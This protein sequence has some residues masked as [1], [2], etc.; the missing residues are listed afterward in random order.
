MDLVNGYRKAAKHLI[1]LGLIPAPCKPELQALWRESPEDRQ[2]VAEI[3]Q[4]W[5]TTP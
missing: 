2:L 1:G 3:T 4:R 5:E